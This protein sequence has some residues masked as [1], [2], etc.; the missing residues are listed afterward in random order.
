M[1]KIT[2]IIMIALLGVSSILMGCVDNGGDIL[3]S[4][5][6]D[7][8]QS[9]MQEE[10]ELDYEIDLESDYYAMYPEDLY[11][12]ADLVISAKYLKNV[13]TY[14]TDYGRIASIAEFEINNIFKGQFEP[15]TIHVQYYGGSVSIEEYMKNQPGGTAE[16]LGVDKLTAE[17]M[18]GKTVGY[19][20]TPT[21]VNAITGSNYLCYLSYDENM[22]TYIVMAD[23]HGMRMA[24][25][26]NEFF[27]PISQEYEAIEGIK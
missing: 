1:K 25:E 23:A 13:E 7:T 5:E 27:S 2:L 20:K 18:K 21:T 22:D 19:F 9:N 17:E 8:S 14:V 10:I 3:N 11:E 16:K 4:T 12:I 24:N 26:N 6:A 15:E